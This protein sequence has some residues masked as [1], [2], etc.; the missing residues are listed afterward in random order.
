[1][2]IEEFRN[3]DRAYLDWVGSSDG[4]VINIQQTLNPSDARLH[5]VTAAPPELRA[6][7]ETADRG[8]LER[9]RCST[10]LEV[11]SRGAPHSASHL[12]RGTRWRYDPC[13]C[14]TAT[15]H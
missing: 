9:Q 2:T 15:R 13:L 6:E 8:I 10:S 3:D 5:H 1:M 14:V 12:T 7:R 11:H 4:Y